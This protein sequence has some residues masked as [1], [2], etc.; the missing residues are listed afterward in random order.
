MRRKV[1]IGG[2]SAVI[3]L[4]TAILVGISTGMIHVGDSDAPS[5]EQPTDEES[6]DDEPTN[7]GEL[8]SVAFIDVGQGDAIFIET[9]DDK[10]VLIDAGPSSAT[11]TVVS[12]I[13][14]EAVTIIDVFIL[15]H[16]DADH[17]GGAS[18]V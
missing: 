5:D 12:H 1:A 7:G 9:P 8:L 4:A 11:S 6:P 16:P 17:I 10:H 14:T 2:T 3:T 15:T 13:D 18:G